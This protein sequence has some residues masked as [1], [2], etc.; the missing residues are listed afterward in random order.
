MTESSSDS[1]YLGDGEGAA[2]HLDERRHSNSTA[3][4]TSSAWSAFRKTSSR[5]SPSREGLHDEMDGL[6]RSFEVTRPG[7]QR[8]LSET[9]VEMSRQRRDVGTTAHGMRSSSSL[10]LDK[11]DEDVEDLHGC[12]TIDSMRVSRHS[13]AVSLS[14]SSGTRTRTPSSNTI[15][16]AASNSTTPVASARSPASGFA[17]VETTNSPLQDSTASDRIQS[18][19]SSSS[20]VS[21]GEEDS[22]EDSIWALS[23]PFSRR[24]NDWA[25]SS[26]SSASSAVPSG[27]RT[28]HKIRPHISIGKGGADGGDSPSPTSA[29]E[30]DISESDQE[31]EPRQLCRR[32]P[33]QASFMTDTDASFSSARSRF[34]AWD[35]LTMDRDSL[36]DYGR[37][38]NLLRL[39]SLDVHGKGGTL[40]A[41]RTGDEE[42]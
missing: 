39:Q 16:N 22:Q 3:S 38:L 37:Q 29:R 13:P 31:E 20:S 33:S 35:T 4:S 24:T 12:S 23:T 21:S 15:V 32:I 40:A 11:I 19:S 7:V 28:P 18:S 34:G 5:P 41:S 10:N 1:S 25:R 17:Q 42:L 30:L 27:S 2:D 14:L 26:L 6:E 36:D 8:S 9:A